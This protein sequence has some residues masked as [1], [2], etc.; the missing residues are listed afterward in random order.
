MAPSGRSLSLLT[1]TTLQWI[2]IAVAAELVLA[3]L[4][5]SLLRLNERRPLRTRPTDRFDR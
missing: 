3:M 2:I 5:G 4:V 1:M